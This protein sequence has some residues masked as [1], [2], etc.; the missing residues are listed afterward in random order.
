M[1]KREQEQQKQQALAAAEAAAAASLPKDYYA[2]LNQGV[3]QKRALVLERKRTGQWNPPPNV[4]DS[5]EQEP[6]EA[7]GGYDDHRDSYDQHHNRRSNHSSGH[8]NHHSSST[9]H[10]QQH[11]HHQHQHQ[12]S[13]GHHHPQH[14]HNARAHEAPSTLPTFTP[15]EAARLGIPPGLASAT[16]TLE[17]W[18][19]VEAGIEADKARAAATLVGLY[20]CRIQ[21]THSA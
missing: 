15:A 4:Y 7:P 6:N 13:N 2:H 5:Q 17:D 1:M 14:H 8:H 16:G 18:E 21:W 12:Q 10:Q 11:R 19:V 9:S 3:T 20:S